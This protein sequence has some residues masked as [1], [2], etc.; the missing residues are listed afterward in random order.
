MR[1][2]SGQPP[3][4]VSAP[5]A[6]PSCSPCGGSRRPCSPLGPPGACAAAP[7]AVLPPRFPGLGGCSVLGLQ[8]RGPL[9]SRPGCGAC[10]RSCCSSQRT[11]H[12]SCALG[13]CG[14]GGRAGRPMSRV[15]VGTRGFPPFSRLSPSSLARRGGLGQLR[16]HVEFNFT[17]VSSP[18][19]PRLILR[20]GER[21]EVEKTVRPEHLRWRAY[22]GRPFEAGL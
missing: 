20:G 13:D 22:K 7:K 1:L 10:G 14:R 2:P 18:W 12:H 17:F 15:C 16:E 3:A 11:L 5:L 6:V 9:C 19:S 4:G 8:M 21:N